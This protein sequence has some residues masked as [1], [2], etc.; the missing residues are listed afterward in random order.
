LLRGNT[1]IERA[2]LKDI[3]ININRNI[4]DSVFNFNFVID[5]FTGNKSTTTRP[6]TAELK[7][8]LDKLIF[9]NVA[10]RFNDSRGGTNFNTQIDTLHSTLSRFQPDRLQLFHDDFMASDVKYYMAMDEPAVRDTLSSKDESG[11]PLLITAQNFDLR[12]LDVNIDDNA[13][14]MYFSSVIPRLGL[15]EA[16]FDLQQTTGNAESLLLDSS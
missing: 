16:L 13:S 14:G 1:D 12:Q 15:N 10:V 2:F 6:D 5:A 9:S 11:V 3:V 8:S 7:L 4:T